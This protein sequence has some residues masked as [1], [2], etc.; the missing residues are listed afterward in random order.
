[1]ATASSTSTVK[2]HRSPSMQTQSHSV[3]KRSQLL[4]LLP[5]SRHSLF[6]VRLTIHQLWNVP[7]VDGSFS[8]KWK[9]HN[10]HSIRGSSTHKSKSTATIN[11][12]K[13][14]SK[15]K[16]RAVSGGSDNASQTDVL[17]A[18]STHSESSSSKAPS[19]RMPTTPLS[20]NSSPSLPSTPLAPLGDVSA[21]ARGRTEYVELVDH[22]VKWG[23]SVGV[24][25][26][27]DV[28]RETMELQPSELKLTVDQVGLTYLSTSKLVKFTEF[29]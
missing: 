24:A 18:A 16:D 5:I 9:F 28:H 11:G 10:V 19:P 17:A 14:K 13:T 23:H 15:G 20:P 4:D 29:S 2:P 26:Q 1:M 8:V 22:N 3:A 7:L 12:T 27:M 25:V 21:E 6:H